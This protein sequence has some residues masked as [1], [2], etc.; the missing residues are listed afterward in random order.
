MINELFC[1]WLAYHIWFKSISR[2]KPF[3]MYIYR[4]YPGLDAF[5]I[6]GIYVPHLDVIAEGPI[7]AVSCACQ[8]MPDIDGLY[9]LNNISGDPELISK[10]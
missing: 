1:G 6:N 2:P 4:I 7:H 5:E 3:L 9:S 8:I 10:F